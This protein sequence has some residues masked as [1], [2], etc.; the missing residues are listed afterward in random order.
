MPRGNAEQCLGFSG[1]GAIGHSRT[2]EVCRARNGGKVIN[3]NS[4]RT[5]R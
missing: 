4:T 1:C 3:A 5:A 2:R